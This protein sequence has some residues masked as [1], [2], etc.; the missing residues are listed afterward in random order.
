M[1]SS[2]YFSSV[3]FVMLT[4]VGRDDGPLKEQKQDSHVC[5]TNR[6]F[7]LMSR[8]NQEGTTLRGLA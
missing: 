8:K 2:H 5:R 6:T 7:P 4:V 1:E 3:K